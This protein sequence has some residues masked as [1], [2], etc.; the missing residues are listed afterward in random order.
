MSIAGVISHVV[1]AG[2]DFWG[3]ARAVA[4]DIREQ[5]RLRNA[6]ALYDLIYANGPPEPSPAEAAV[7]QGLALR[8]PWCS[9]FYEHRRRAGG[10]TSGRTCRS[11][12]WVSSSRRS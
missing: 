2:R 12:A 8:S 3:V 4:A 10:G 11:R 7:L 9:M 1:V 6:H 5:L